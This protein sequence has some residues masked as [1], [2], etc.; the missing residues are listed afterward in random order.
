LVTAI[1]TCGL[2]SDRVGSIKVPKLKSCVFI[3]TL[4]SNAKLRRD[5]RNAMSYIGRALPKGFKL[6]TAQDVCSS[7]FNKN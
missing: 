1:S 4:S 6:V 7:S 3:D 5:M 2:A